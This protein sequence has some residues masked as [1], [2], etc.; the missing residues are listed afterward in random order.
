V[1]RVTTAAMP[2]IAPHE[3]LSQG[4]AQAR[5]TA[6][7][8]V[9]EAAWYGAPMRWRYS[10]L[11]SA[12]LLVSSCGGGGD[13]AETTE[14][15]GEVAF[16]LSEQGDAGAVGV[17]A[18][19]RYETP[20]QTTVVV[21]GLDE[22]EPA[23]GGANPVFLRSGTCDDP[24]EILFDLQKLS[25]ATSDTTVDLALTALLNGDYSIQVALPDRPDDIVACGN[26]PQEVA[27]P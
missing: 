20:E 10:I 26:V 4:P 13:K 11:L 8:F 21:D 14:Q 18:T 25:G 24:G 17:R 9:Y 1:A 19:L 27:Q 16:E 12:S 6:L 7:S 5:H 22:G 15:P 2:K 23:G 3:S